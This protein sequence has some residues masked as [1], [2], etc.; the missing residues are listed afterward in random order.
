MIRSAAISIMS[1]RNQNDNMS[2][3][4]Q[5]ERPVAIISS[6]NNRSSQ[7]QQIYERSVIG[8]SAHFAQDGSDLQSWSVIGMNLPIQQ[9]T[10]S[11]LKLDVIEKIDWIDIYYL[12]YQI[13]K[14]L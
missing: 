13:I 7:I 12:R 11:I 9:P 8:Q 10:K 2:T 14:I 4:Q 3:L 6:D 1:K 5:M